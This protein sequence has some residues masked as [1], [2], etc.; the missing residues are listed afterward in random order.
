MAEALF[1]QTE[2]FLHYRSD[3]GA[4]ASDFDCERKYPVRRFAVRESPDRMRIGMEE[5][6][7][8]NDY[9]PHKISSSDLKRPHI[10]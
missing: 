9:P 7:Y 6:R 10:S 1:Q 2:I 8:C 5:A 4:S 3:E